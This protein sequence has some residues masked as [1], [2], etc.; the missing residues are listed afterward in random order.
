MPSPFPGRQRGFWAC[1]GKRSKKLPQAVDA[2]SRFGTLPRSLLVIATANAGQRRCS[3]TIEEADAWFVIIADSF[4]S[5]RVVGGSHVMWIESQVPMAFAMFSSCRQVG[6]GVAGC[7]EISSAGSLFGS[8]C[9]VGPESEVST[10]VAFGLVTASHDC[11]QATKSARWMPRRR[12]AM[13]DVAG[14]DKP[15]GAVKLA[16]IRGSP[17]RETG[18]HWATRWY[19]LRVNA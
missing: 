15:R 13:K 1:W 17:N 11:G 12:E 5:R 9:V 4:P 18:Y 14:C 10:L 19:H 8:S 2:R 7:I 16:L 3:L 6:R